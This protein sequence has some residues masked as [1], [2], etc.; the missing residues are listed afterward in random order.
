MERQP[1][2]KTAGT[3]EQIRF[4][5]G[6]SSMGAVLVAQSEQGICA[7]F[8]GDDPDA[9]IRELQDRFPKAHLM[10]SG[11][12][13]SRVIEQVVEF[14]ENPEAGLPLPLDIRGTEFQARVWR[15]LQEIPAG[16]TVSYTDIAERIGSPLSVRAVASA[17]GANAIAVAIP[18]HRVLRRD[19]GLSG[20]R[21]GVA[22]KHVLLEREGVS[23]LA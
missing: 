21:W 9:L 18:C 14:I 2:N 20:Y 6:Q 19:G 11:D 1:V 22:R 16:S 15:A 8:L 17:C 10:D 3:S 7:I 23:L 13:Y 4:G 5:I 12:G